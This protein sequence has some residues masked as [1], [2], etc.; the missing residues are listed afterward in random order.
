MKKLVLTLVMGVF[1]FGSSGFKADE[2]YS[3]DC[4]QYAMAQTATV[5]AAHRDYFD[6]AGPFA[7]LD[8]YLIWES[9]CE[10]NDGNVADVAI[11]P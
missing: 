4:Q 6:S 5:Y 8:E 1:A 3:Q 10:E 9:Y 7:M 11:V 2:Y